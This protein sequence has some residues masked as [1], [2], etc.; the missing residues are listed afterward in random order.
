MNRGVLVYSL[1]LVAAMGGAYAVWTTPNSGV[2]S[3]GVTLISGVMDELQR[4]HY[5]TEKLD[6]VL[7]RRTDDRGAFGWVRVESASTV[8]SGVDSPAESGA[9][10]APAESAARAQVQVSEFKAGRAAEAVMSGMMPFVARRQLEHLNQDQLSELGLD[11]P[12]ATIEITRQGRESKRFEIGGR[13][14]GGRNL[15][16]RDP[17]TG[18]VYVIEASL[19]RPLDNPEQT[20]LDRDVVGVDAREIERIAVTRDGREATFEQHNAAD[21]SAA[22]WSP[23]GNDRPDAGAGAW[24]DRALRLRIQSYVQA[25]DATPALETVVQ[26]AVHTRAGTVV[27][28][29][30]LVARSDAGEAQWFARSQYTRALVRLEGSLPADVAADVARLFAEGL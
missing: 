23:A 8:V 18:H 25:G 28:T 15:Y 4:L 12:E 1:L 21:A 29:E 19:L 17:E 5:H 22:Y 14:Y 3:D 24:I 9:E 20:L 13:V 16:A 2:Q 11:Q 30:L 7:E 27:E 6:V 26:F 10:G